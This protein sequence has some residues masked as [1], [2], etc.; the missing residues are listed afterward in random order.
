MRAVSNK[1]SGFSP[2]ICPPEK[3]VPTKL[4]GEPRWQSD[5]SE[6]PCA[7]CPA[8][9]LGPV[10]N[11]SKGIRRWQKPQNKDGNTLNH[12][13]TKN[14]NV[15]ETILCGKP[16][17]LKT[18]KTYWKQ[19]DIPKIFSCW[20]GKGPIFQILSYHIPH[21]CTHPGRLPGFPNLV[22]LVTQCW[23]YTFH[24]GP[25]FGQSNWWNLEGP[26]ILMGIILQP[27][28]YIERIGFL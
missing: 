26:M 19:H 1:K 11:Q 15:W 28:D 22:A 13:S 20:T 14:E 9:G 21:T 17:K 10:G 4:R 27:I 16:F 5:P 8:G 6:R 7:L 12:M 2:T 3:S 25:A 18:P 24:L 23:I